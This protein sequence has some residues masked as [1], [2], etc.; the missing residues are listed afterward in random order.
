MTNP[1]D[2]PHFDKSAI[3]AVRCPCGCGNRAEACGATWGL[4]QAGLIKAG[5]TRRMIDNRCQ[6]V[7]PSCSLVLAL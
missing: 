1:C 2:N 6:Y 5:W 3:I 7:C 4:V